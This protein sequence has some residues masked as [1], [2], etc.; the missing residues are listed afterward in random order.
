MIETLYDGHVHL[1]GCTPWH[2]LE[3]Y[4]PTQ[5]FERLRAE[6]TRLQAGAPLKD[7][8]KSWFPAIEKAQG[9]LDFLEASAAAAVRAFT[10]SHPHAKGFDLRFC[11]FLRP[12]EPG[13]QVERILKG[14][15]SAAAA[16]DHVSL[17]VCSMRGNHRHLSAARELL[18]SGV[19]GLDVAGPENHAEQG[20]GWLD[21]VAHLYEDAKAAGLFTTYHT[22]EGDREDCLL[23]L[24]RLPMLDRVGH[25]VALRKSVFPGEKLPVFELCPSVNDI[26][27]VASF[28]TV[29]EFA[30]ELM[31]KGQEFVF[32]SD[33]PVVTGVSFAE[34]WEMVPKAVRDA[35][36]ATSLRIAHC[37]KAP[38]WSGVIC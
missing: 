12:A 17:T 20:Y 18:G 11:P 27:G 2:T 34:Q 28:W 35:A 14:L 5:D 29:M 6:A 24:D 1:G 25:G 26:T 30:L 21:S 9:N 16:L 10:A 7:F 13:A 19:D 31:R 38:P 37:R 22:G 4:L 23:A 15:R 8:L 36:S 32:G 3:D 33:N